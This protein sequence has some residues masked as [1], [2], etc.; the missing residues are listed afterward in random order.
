MRKLFLIV[1]VLLG[2][3][4]AL[5]HAQAD[6][7]TGAHDVPIAARSFNLLPS[8]FIQPLAHMQLQLN[9]TI[10]HEF[11]SVQSARSVAAILTILT[12]AFFYGVLHAAGPGH[13]KT[14]VGSYFVA[15]EAR[16]RAGVLMGGL[17]SLMQ[18][19]TAIAIVFLMSLALHAKE[20][21]VANQ[22]ALVDCVSYG[23]VAVIGAVLFWRAATGRG[24]EHTHP[25]AM[26]RPIGDAH[27]H[28][29]LH[30][31]GAG[32]HELAHIHHDHGGDVGAR[33][34]FQRTLVLAT[35][36]APCASAIIIMLFALANHA[37]GIGIAAVL[38]LSLG[39]AITVSAVG[40]LGIMARRLLIRMTAGARVERAERV[41]R[42]L[43]SAAIFGFAS[44]LM[45]GALSQ[46]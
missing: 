45:L 44:L 22:S 26:R 14:V 34:G 7:F 19:L 4:A 42:L 13:G 21:Q 30:A 39:M 2:V 36:V 41:A 35:G 16:W 1:T 31:G 20:F 5:T 28:G 38:A 11:Q 37:M 18:G 15:N 32:E 10:S 23:F 40:I 29:A 43:G 8:W 33:G 24:C 12:L 27:D 46:L 9:E 6:P 3:A 25:P 17:I